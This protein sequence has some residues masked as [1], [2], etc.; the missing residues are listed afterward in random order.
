MDWIRIEVKCLF[1]GLFKGLGYLV[2]EM[3]VLVYFDCI[4][5]CCKGD[6]FCYVLFGGKGVI[7]VDGDL[8]GG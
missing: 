1:K 3:V 6:V 2:V 7:F 8:F 5:L 4:G